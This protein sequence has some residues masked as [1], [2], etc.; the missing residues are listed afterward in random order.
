MI[1][2]LFYQLLFVLLVLLGWV[3]YSHRAEIGDAYQ[4]T[5]AMID[6]VSREAKKAVGE[7]ESVIE[8]RP[9]GASN[10]APPV[11]PP[12]GYAAAYGNASSETQIYKWQDANG[13]W[14]FSTQQPDTADASN[15]SAI[16]MGDTNLS[17]VESALEEAVETGSTND[18]QAIPGIPDPE[19]VKKLFDDVEQL[20]KKHENRVQDLDK[21]IDSRS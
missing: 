4:T 13:T 1:K 19:V 3:G 9:S 7:D 6:Q 21:L 18:L 10:N 17:V 14:H 11:D 15:V 12:P 16:N 2:A 8:I 5:M 20:Q